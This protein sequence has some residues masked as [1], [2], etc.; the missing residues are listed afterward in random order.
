MTDKF[1][2]NGQKVIS[3][4][5]ELSKNLNHHFLSVAHIFTALSDVESALFAEM[6]QSVGIN[7]KSITHLLEQELAKKPQY[8]G[9]ALAV[10]E[11]TMDLLKFALGRARSLGR[12]HIEPH[13]IFVGLFTDSNGLPV[14]MLRR[15]G[16]DPANAAQTISQR[17]R[18]R[19]EQTQTFRRS[20]AI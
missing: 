7:P 14:E 15:L 16:V 1:S 9:H 20:E 4:A 6:M 3:R 17:I 19:E 5:I 2:E 12:Q 10:T 11:Q 18:A 13:D 8:L